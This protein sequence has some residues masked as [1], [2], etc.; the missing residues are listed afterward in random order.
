MQV[1]GAHPSWPALH[2][3]GRR[4]PRQLHLEVDMHVEG[5]QG[6][7]NLLAALQ[8]MGHELQSFLSRWNQRFP[9]TDERWR[10]SRGEKSDA[11]GLNPAQ[12]PFTVGTPDPG[13][14]CWPPPVRCT[15]PVCVHWWKACAGYTRPSPYA[16]EH[17]T[18]PLGQVLSGPTL[19]PCL[20]LGRHL[21]SRQLVFKEVTSRFEKAM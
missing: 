5:R 7:W 14:D 18:P 16:V 3:F 21:S 1:D 9:A 15:S 12:T 8:K 4:E 20:A 17:K 6:L 19:R 2:G 13:L 11:G 10:S